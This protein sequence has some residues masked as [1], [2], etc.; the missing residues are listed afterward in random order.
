VP[1]ASKLK[2][3]KTVPQKDRATGAGSGWCLSYALHERD[4]AD[5]RARE[6]GKKKRGETTL[7][8]H[9][10]VLA[11]RGGDREGKGLC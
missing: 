11:D 2:R 1:T 10:P 4:R 7:G 6:A 9:A 5:H 3:K 8:V